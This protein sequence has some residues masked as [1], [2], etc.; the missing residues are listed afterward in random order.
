MALVMVVQPKLAFAGGAFVISEG[1]DK[2]TVPLS[3]ADPPAQFKGDKLNMRLG[4][5]L[6]TFDKSGLGIRYRGKGGF[7]TLAYMSTSPKI[8][9]TEEIVRNAE[10]AKSGE[11]PARVSAVSGFEV[12]N[13]RLYLLLRW[14]DKSGKPWLETLVDVDTSGD[15]PKINLIGRFGGFSYTSGPVCDELYSTGTKLFVVLRGVDGLA[16]GTC[17]T[18]QGTTAFKKLAPIVDE[19]H[20]FG[21]L[22]YTVTKTPH[23]MKS[24]GIVNPVPERFRTVLETRG[25]IARSSLTSALA[26]KEGGHIS[27]FAFVSGA[28]LPIEDGSGFAETTFG[29][30]VWSPKSKPVRATL[31][32][33]ETW[34]A[35]SEWKSVGP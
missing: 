17:D 23:G 32:E 29:V 13:D 21:S 15:A 3:A 26:V 16:L 31:R 12:V 8:F 22:F 4:D 14:D 30:L 19:C 11:R 27:L 34:A 10:L 24:V 35:I 5:T 33:T 1:E 9:S 18:L 25:E 20:R 28:K 6:I 7:T 2:L